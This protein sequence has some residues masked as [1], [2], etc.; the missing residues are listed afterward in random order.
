MYLVQFVKD[1]LLDR[2]SAPTGKR[3]PL[4]GLDLYMMHEVTTNGKHPP[5]LG[6]VLFDARGYLRMGKIPGKDLIAN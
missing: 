3:V 4:F 2:I 1:L 5:S 6:L